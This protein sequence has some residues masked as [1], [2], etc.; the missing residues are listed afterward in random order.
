MWPETIRRLLRAGLELSTQIGGR[1]RNDATE[2]RVAS[3]WTHCGGVAAVHRFAWKANEM[4]DEPEMICPQNMGQ[5]SKDPDHWLTDRWTTDETIAKRQQQEFMDRNPTGSIGEMNG[6]WAWSWGP[7]RTCSYCGGIHP[8]DAILLVKEGWEVETTGKSY[9]RYLGPPGT[10]Q[11][12]VSVMNNLRNG[13]GTL[14]SV[15][16]VW[17]PTPPVKMYVYHFSQEQIE[18]FNAALKAGE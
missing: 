8:D 10:H 11:R 4:T 13:D 17:S 5:F 9:K 14:Q 18:R 7:P 6:L 16:S 1:N 15:P 3:E 2:C 12:H